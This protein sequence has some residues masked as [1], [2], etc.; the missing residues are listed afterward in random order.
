MIASL[1]IGTELL[2]SLAAFHSQ[3]NSFCTILHDLEI[4]RFHTTFSFKMKVSRYCFLIF[5]TNISNLR[6][7]RV[8][9]YYIHDALIFAY[10]FRGIINPAQCSLCLI[11]R[12]TRDIYDAR[13]WFTSLN[14]RH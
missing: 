12:Y 3:V 7:T 8:L 9:L 5:E 2:V 1:V 14:T 4:S 6:R 13:G 10:L 11:G